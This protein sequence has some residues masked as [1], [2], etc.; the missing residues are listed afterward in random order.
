L[1]LPNEYDWEV[2][3]LKVRLQGTRNDIKWFL[4]LLGR[5]SR[6]KLMNKSE[7]LDNKGTVKY[8]RAYTEIY[9]E[10]K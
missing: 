5:D 1:K 2:F 6:F 4:K 10:K 8:K 7:I 9:R 3:M